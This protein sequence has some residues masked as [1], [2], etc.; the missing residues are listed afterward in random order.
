MAPAQPEATI[1]SEI[2]ATPSDRKVAV[3]TEVGPTPSKP[4]REK[5]EGSEED[6]AQRPVVRK[7]SAE[8]AAEEDQGEKEN[9]RDVSVTRRES[10]SKS[11]VK[12]AKIT[13]DVYKVTS[14]AD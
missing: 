2:P 14:L 11:R 9:R 4:E 8:A 1:S 10:V 5:D 13:H 3:E 7:L 6:K 12:V